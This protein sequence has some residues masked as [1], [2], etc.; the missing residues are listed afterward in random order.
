MTVRTKNWRNLFFAPVLLVLAGISLFYGYAIDT[1][2][3]ALAAEL[4]NIVLFVILHVVL[5]VGGRV[6]P[7]FSDRG[8]QR[9]PT[10]T[11]VSL[12][13]V[14]LLSSLLFLGVLIKGSEETVLQRVALLV[15]AANAVRWL[16][17]KPWQTLSVPL[18]WSLQAAYATL[19]L[20]F[21]MIALDAPTSAA[22][23]ALAVGGIGLMI[24]AMIS[25]VSLG[26]TGRPLQLAPGYV[27]AFYL[28][29][30]AILARVL[31]S[32]LPAWYFPLLWTAALAWSAAYGMFLYYYLPMLISPRPDGR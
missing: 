6:I 4:L 28:L 29:I 11:I 12:E 24:L 25:R 2:S 30:A 15:F 5:V 16:H 26:H 3:Q 23:H 21:L 19:V 8:L 14:A 17:W 27:A 31:A 13:W 10:T 7:F 18:L 9:P 32:L 22:I 20:G 1:S